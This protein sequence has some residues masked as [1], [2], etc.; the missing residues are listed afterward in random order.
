MRA[1][2][3]VGASLASVAVMLGRVDVT[4]FPFVELPFMDR[5]IAWDHRPDGTVYVRSRVPLK[6]IEPHVPFLLRR[7]AEEVPDRVWYAQRRGPERAWTG[8]TYGEGRRQ[9]DA[10]TQALL[11]LGLPGRNVMVLSANSLEF[12]VLEAAAMQARMPFVA[13]TPAYAAKALDFTRLRAMVDLIDPAVLFVQDAEAYGRALD[14]VA[15]DRV[16][17]AVGGTPRTE[18]AWGRR[19]RRWQDLIATAVTPAV[20][21]SVAEISH[22]TVAKF[23]FT[24]GSTGVPKAVIHTHGTLMTMNASNEI[25]LRRT[26]RDDQAG[27][28][29]GPG[30]LIEWT[31]W[32]H[33]SGGNSLYCKVLTDRATCYIDDGRPTPAEFGE[34]LRNLREISP[35]HFASMPL[36]YAMLVD[37]LDDDAQLRATFFKSLRSLV[38]SGARLPD[39][40]NHRIQEHAVHEAGHR[41]PF[42][43]GFGSTETSPSCGFTYW[44]TERMGMIGLPQAGVT[45]KLVPLEPGRYE[46]RVKSGSVTP[47]Y[48]RNPELTA[49]AFDDEGFY[50]MGDAAALADPD[51]PDEGLVFAG[52]LAEEFKL[53]SGTFVR[54]TSLRVSIL[55]AVSPLLREVV[56][57]GADQPYVAVLAWPDA[58]AAES[59]GAASG[60]D[61]RTFEPLRARLRSLLAAYNLDHPG[62]SMRVRRVKLMTEPFSQPAGEINDKGYVNQRRVLDLRSHEVE[63]LFADRP[64]PTI[65]ELP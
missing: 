50:R 11:D 22:D 20:D 33:V 31:P 4:T 37:A 17:V 45:F 65:I 54:V 42:I 53:T 49:A 10:V 39:E 2:T 9:A 8:L 36:G 28:P 18:L 16:V 30:E 52:R 15:G 47:G 23:V 61:L 1:L 41:I 58:H 40:I 64:D 24:S 5:D 21:A 34:T 32:S 7:A 57:A 59:L 63:E 14:A 43:S 51:D 48:Y 26:E 56:V 12:A 27:D 19:V 46:L 3:E 60:T 38:Y 35:A 62:S 29:D 6:A 55:D 13:T 25:R 44:P